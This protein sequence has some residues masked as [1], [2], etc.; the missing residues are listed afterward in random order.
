MSRRKEMRNCY[1]G[2]QDGFSG[3]GEVDDMS[4]STSDTT[5]LIDEDLNVLHDDAELV[6]VGARFTTA[7]ITTIRAITARNANCQFQITIGA[8]TMGTYT[9]TVNGVTSAAINGTDDL[10]AVT[11]ALVAMSNIAA[12]D[13]TVTEPTTDV[14]L[15]EFKGVF[16]DT[17]VTVSATPTMLDNFATSTL[18]V[19]G[20][21]WSLTFT[22]A[23]AAGETIIDGDVITYLPQRII[24]KVGDGDFE[25]TENDDPIFD[26]DRDRLDGVR[27]GKEVPMDVTT[28]SVVNFLKSSSGDQVTFYEALHRTGGAAD[29]H[30]S[31]IDP[32]EPYCIDLF[33]LDIPPCGSEDA[34]VMYFRR[35]YPTSK[36]GT[37]KDGVLEITGKCNSL[38]P[39]VTRE[40]LELAVIL[41]E[42]GLEA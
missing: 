25:W 37:I 9:V 42:F 24:A 29:W 36:R 12:A 31:A 33:V 3:T 34:E 8:D 19:G 40:A 20:K 10:A 32:C 13:I 4:I 38:K 17:A 18:H 41:E 28:S 11:A 26:S 7:G 22:P 21:T 6:P 1:I 16:L 2:A 23:V 30:N 5:I 15:I 27:A 14:F 35:F 39:E